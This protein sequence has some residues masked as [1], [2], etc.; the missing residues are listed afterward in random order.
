MP[1]S[2][3]Q[4][5]PR[6]Q[7]ILS[8]LTTAIA[9]GVAEARATNGYAWT[10]IDGWDGDTGAGI[11]DSLK[12][13]FDR[14]RLL[15]EWKRVTQNADAGTID[16]IMAILLQ[17]DFLSVMHRAASNRHLTRPRVAAYRLARY[18]C[19]GGDDGVL[20]VMIKDAIRRILRAA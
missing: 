20:A 9:E 14:T 13:A 7:E 2:S 16:D 19:Q 6:F 15:S 17:Q 8:S 18:D 12:T 11:E 3:T 1:T 5:D 10:K 4:I